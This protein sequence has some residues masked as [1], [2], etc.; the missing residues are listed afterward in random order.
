MIIS[1]VMGASGGN[2][3]HASIGRRVTAAAAASAG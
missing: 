1:S 3:R 2:W